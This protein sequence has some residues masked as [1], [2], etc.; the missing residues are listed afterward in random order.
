MSEWLKL[1]YKLFADIRIRVL[2]V[3]RLAGCPPEG[4]GYALQIA[5]NNLPVWGPYMLTRNNKN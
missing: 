1:R 2:Q 3:A 4:S 5:I